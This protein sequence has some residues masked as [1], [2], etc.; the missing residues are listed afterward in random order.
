MIKFFRKIRQKML[1]E[2]KFSN[3][4]IYAIGE[5]ILVVIGILIAL[6]INNSNQNRVIQKKEQTYLNGLKA[7]FQTSKFKLSELIKINKSNFY[8]AKKLLEDISNK[9][10]SPSEK[11]FSELLLNTFSSD[12]S[13]NPNNSLL[14]EMISS[15]SLKDISNTTLR[16]KLTNWISTIED[17]SKQ[18]SELGIQREKVLDIFRTNEN[19]LRT[20]FDLTGISQEIGLQKMEQSVSNLD[21]LKSR[22]F[23]NNILMFILTTNAMEK[24]HY[25]PLMKDL[26]SIIELIENE[27]K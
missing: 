25:E 11:Q 15:G 13:F 1:I 6:A 8:G 5:I 9:N 18:E 12:I 23:E 24:A 21:L 17:V 16:I 10:E 26:E 20:I 3:Y 27:I 22:K 14:S 4:L 7:E 2:N 19:S